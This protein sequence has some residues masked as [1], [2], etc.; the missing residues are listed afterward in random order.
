MCVYV[1]IYWFLWFS[2]LASLQATYIYAIYPCPL[3]TLNTASL[4][5]VECAIM[6]KAK[7]YMFSHKCVY[8]Q[9]Y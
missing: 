6:F 8:L 9:M 5:N 2:S 1:C 3:S 4:T 7:I